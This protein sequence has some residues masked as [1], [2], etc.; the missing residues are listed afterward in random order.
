VRLSFHLYNND[1]DV[2]HVLE[3]ARGLQ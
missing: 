1:D 2:D 3:V